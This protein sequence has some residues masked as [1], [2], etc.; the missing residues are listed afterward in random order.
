M[1]ARALRSR[2]EPSAVARAR[3][4]PAVFGTTECTARS[5]PGQ[6]AAG[7][8]HPRGD[9]SPGPLQG[10]VSLFRETSRGTPRCPAAGLRPGEARGADGRRDGAAEPVPQVPLALLA[11][12]AH[13]FEIPGFCVED[14]GLV[15]SFRD[16]NPH[17]FPRSAKSPRSFSGRAHQASPRPHN[18]RWHHRTAVQ[19]S[20]NKPARFVK[21]SMVPPTL[22]GAGAR[23]G[24]WADAAVAGPPSG[25]PPHLG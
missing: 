15:E 20:E 13:E 16:G 5:A 12:F 11:C 10:L 3:Q 6:I 1:S 23:A 14:S 21:R 7:R 4:H 9:V 19:D 2:P 18:S 8:G 24:G 25:C 22:T 17:K